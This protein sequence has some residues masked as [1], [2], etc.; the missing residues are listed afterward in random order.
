MVILLKKVFIAGLL[1][2]G[3]ND[4]IKNRFTGISGIITVWVPLLADGIG[5]NKD[6]EQILVE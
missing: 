1:I 2:F 4:D 5:R 6:K 3:L